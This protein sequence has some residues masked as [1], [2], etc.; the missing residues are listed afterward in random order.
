MK[1]LI[2]GGAGFIG[3][4]LALRINNLYPNFEVTIFDHFNDGT[5]LDTGNF[6]FLGSFN[7]LLGF[8]GK[9][10]C[11]NIC[12]E[13]DLYNLG[14]DFQLIFHLAALSDT[15]VKDENL[16]FCN[17]INP[18]YYFVDL[19]R[20]KGS[21]LVYAS[22]AAVY[23]NLGQH[24]CMVGVESPDNPY[25]YSKWAM[26]N[27]TLNNLLSSGMSVIG[28]RYF[29]VYGFGEAYKFKTASTILQFYN[30]VKN[31]SPIV[32]FEGSDNIYRDFVHIQDVVDVT[33]RAGLLEVKGVFNVGSG[34][35]RTFLDVA[36]GVMNALNV[37]VEINYIPN[38]YRN[39]YQFYTCGNIVDTRKELN[40]SPKFSLE[41]GISEYV[42]KLESNVE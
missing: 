5:L 17:N 8:R 27:F 40:Y 41:D 39:G 25:A 7:N 38:P 37:K 15:R 23:G 14:D 13:I 28:L 11:G 34:S 4:N 16:V 33:L 35:A 31:E 30:N 20:R 26:D 3:S 32:L 36:N 29:N 10:V 2:T 6:K 42:S 21:K 22:S 12:S 1:V 24:N 9:I 19:A 18:F